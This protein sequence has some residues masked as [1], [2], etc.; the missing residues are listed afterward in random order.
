MN[1]RDTKKKT[2]FAQK[3]NNISSKDQRA[4]DTE[5]ASGQPQQQIN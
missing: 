4:N 2:I 5:W 1:W 3:T